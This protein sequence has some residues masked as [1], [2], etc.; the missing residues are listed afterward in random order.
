MAETPAPVARFD[1]YLATV[2]LAHEVLW[3]LRRSL[4]AVE[5]DDERVRRLFAE[6]ADL[7]VGELPRVLREARRLRTLWGEQELLDPQ[8]ASRTLELLSDELGRVEPDLAKLRTRQNEI[9]RELR[10]RL[11]QG[12]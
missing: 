11:S 8:G 1:H 9:A 7:V 4:I 10:D 3:E 5:R 6:A 12:D 2:T